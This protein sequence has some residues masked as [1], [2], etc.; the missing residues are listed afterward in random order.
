MGER[1]ITIIMSTQNGFSHTLENCAICTQIGPYSRGLQCGG[2]EEEDSFLPEAGEKLV[3][4]RDLKPWSGTRQ[5]VVRQ[6]PECGTYYL[7]KTDYEYL[8]TGSEDEQELTRLTAEEA[9]AYL[10]RPIEKR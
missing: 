4:I 6:C 7:Y 8:A 10:Q 5:L 2:R 1:Q 3:L 9:Q